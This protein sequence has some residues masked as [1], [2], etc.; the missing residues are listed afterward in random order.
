[1]DRAVP[2]P[3]PIPVTSPP[4]SP[5]KKPIVYQKSR[6]YVKINAGQKMPT[7]GSDWPKSS[8]ALTPEHLVTMKK[9]GED[10]SAIGTPALN[11]QADKIIREEARRKQQESDNNNDDFD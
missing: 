4:T 8:M 1:S 10:T 7:N 3:A 11:A 9:E 2:V 6:T 5:A